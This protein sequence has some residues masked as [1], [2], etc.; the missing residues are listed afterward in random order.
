M[1]IEFNGKHISIESE[2]TVGELLDRLDLKADDYIVVRDGRISRL[3]EL[4]DEDSS[5]II[6]RAIVGG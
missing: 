2:M 1:N 6:L 4:L 3:M 5:V